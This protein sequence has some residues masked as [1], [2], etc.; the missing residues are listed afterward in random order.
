MTVNSLAIV[1][2]PS[3]TVGAAKTNAVRGVWWIIRT[4][5]KSASSVDP[6]DV[7]V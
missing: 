7:D 2:T 6:F 5:P 1:S 3:V 4:K